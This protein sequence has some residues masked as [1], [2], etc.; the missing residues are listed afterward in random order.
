MMTQLLL[1]CCILLCIIF[2]GS[3][4]PFGEQLH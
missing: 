2:M 4:T 1:L 3:S